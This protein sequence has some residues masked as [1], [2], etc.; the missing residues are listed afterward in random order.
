LLEKASEGSSQVAAFASG[1]IFYQNENKQN[2]VQNAGEKSNWFLKRK[3][4]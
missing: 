3:D 4:S 1:Q 2:H